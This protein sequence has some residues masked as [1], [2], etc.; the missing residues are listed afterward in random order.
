M[1]GNRRIVP[2]VLALALAGCANDAERQAAETICD[3]G[4]HAKSMLVAHVDRTGATRNGDID[5]KEFAE[6]TSNVASA[7]ARPKVPIY[8]RKYRTDCRNK[9]KDYWYPCLKALEVDL[10][11]VRGLARAAKL[12]PAGRLAIVLCERRVQTK[13]LGLPTGDLTSADKECELLDSRLC[14]VR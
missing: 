13:L 5:P 9:E 8:S 2:L 4:V 11:Q 1:G 10:S 12:E 7:V 3:F 6:F 14:P